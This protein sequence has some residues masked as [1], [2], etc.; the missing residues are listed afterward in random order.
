MPELLSD[1]LLLE[2]S[3]EDDFE[4]PDFESDDDELEDEEEPEVSLL[5]V[6]FFDDPLESVA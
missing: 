4:E 2:L 6:L 3:V 5:V 1:P